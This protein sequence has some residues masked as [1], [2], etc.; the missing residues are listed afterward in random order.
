MYVLEMG[1]LPPVDLFPF[2]NWVPERLAGWKRQVMDVKRRQ[3]VLFGGLLRQVKE[4]VDGGKSTGCFMEEA[5]RCREE[6]GLS[7]AMLMY[8]SSR[9]CACRMLNDPIVSSRHLGG[10]LLEGSDTSSGVLQYF[11]LLMVAYP[12]VQAKAQIEVDAIVNAARIPTE[13]DIERMPY[14]R[15]LIEEVSCFNLPS[16]DALQE[17]G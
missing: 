10:T 9:E 4:R 8:C 3:E 17:L 14:L 11:V 13:E 6:W 7:D 15:A 1:K 12:H 16:L 2:L 5:Y